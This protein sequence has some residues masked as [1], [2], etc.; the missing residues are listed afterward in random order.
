MS[1]NQYVYVMHR[2]S[3]SW[4]GGKEVLKKCQPVIP[5]GSEDRCSGPERRWQINFAADHGWAGYRIQW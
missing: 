5:A 3:K 1:S 4:P 2:L